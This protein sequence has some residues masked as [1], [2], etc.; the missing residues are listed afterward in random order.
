MPHALILTAIPVEYLEVRQHLKSLRKQK[1]P[2][3]G[4]NYERG[5]FIADNRSIWNVNVEIYRHLK[6]LRKD[7]L[8]TEK[9]YGEVRKFISNIQ[10]IYNVVISELKKLLLGKRTRWDV[11]ITEIGLSN[12][13]AADVTTQAI[14]YCNPDIIFF[15]GIAGGIKDVKIGDVVIADKV[16]YYEM[17]KDNKKFSPRPDIRRCSNVLIDQAK[18]IIGSEWSQRIINESMAIINPRAMV[19]AI[20]AGERVLGAKDSETYKLLRETYGDALSV[21][22]ESFGFLQSVANYPKVKALVIRG[23]SDKIEDKNADDPI[24]G[25]ENERQRRASCHASAFAFEMLA[26]LEV[27]I[28]LQKLLRHGLHAM[29]L[30]IL[31]RLIGILQPFELIAYDILMSSRPDEKMD[32]RIAIIEITEQNFQGTE[33]SN[34][35]LLALLTTLKEDYKPEIIGLDVYVDR[36]EKSGNKELIEHLR[37]ANNNIISTCVIVSQ[38]PESTPGGIPPATVPA[39]QLGF[40]N[41]PSEDVLGFN[42]LREPSFIRRYQL[43]PPTPT[44]DEQERLPSCDANFSLGFSLATKYLESKNFTPAQTVYNSE[45]YMEN[46]EGYIEYEPKNIVIE[47]LEAWGGYRWRDVEGYQ[48]LLNYRSNKHGNSFLRVGIDE[49]IAEKVHKDVLANKI[50]LI[51]YTSDIPGQYPDHYYTP[52]SLR[53]PPGQRMPGVL[54]HAHLVSQILSSVIDDRIQIKVWSFYHDLLWIGVLSFI[55]I[56]SIWLRPLMKLW[57]F[58]VIKT[59]LIISMCWFLLSKLGLWVPLVPPTLVA[60]RITWKAHK[61]RVIENKWLT[62]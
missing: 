23:I 12:S 49:V 28:P 52:Q 37:D 62:Q 51:G 60:Y 59:I 34:E 53:F 35:K 14:N 38:K 18:S 33:I 41:V 47:E 15:V 6:S 45:I 46:E 16:Y 42:L 43:T 31:M 54:I 19:G 1:H 30:I 27:S 17:G 22:M 5:K 40:T 8:H 11:T 20:A 56:G 13:N 61:L 44:K 2:I 48:V 39:Q 3:T 25:S 24:E 29:M 32:N 7:N 4:K 10:T 55:S 26:S 50:V 57:L 9:A 21:D 58:A 36:P